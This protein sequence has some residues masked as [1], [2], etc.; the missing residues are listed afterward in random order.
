MGFLDY[1]D[2]IITWKLQQL[3]SYFGILMLNKTLQIC[4]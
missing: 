1:Y 2:K 4:L 3:Q